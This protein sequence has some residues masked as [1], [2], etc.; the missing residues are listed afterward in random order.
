VSG[1]DLTALEPVFLAG[2]KA[3]I[4][5]RPPQRSGKLAVVAPRLAF[6]VVD[7][8][9]PSSDHRSLTIQCESKIRSRGLTVSSVVLLKLGPTLVVS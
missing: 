4:W 8:F 2:T 6:R 9:A 3:R 7:R 5:I 1:F